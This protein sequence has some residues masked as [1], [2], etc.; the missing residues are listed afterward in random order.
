MENH[1]PAKFGGHTHCDC[2][3]IMILGYH[4]IL[5]LRDQRLVWLYRQKPIQVSYH[6]AKFGGYIPCGSEDMVLA[7]H[8]ILQDH[9]IKWSCEFMDR[10]PSG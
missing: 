8:V 5:R 3:V 10:S 1:Q 6:P 7:C 4:M 2:G 9:V